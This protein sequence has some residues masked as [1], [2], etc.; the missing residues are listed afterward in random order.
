M[1]MD[2]NGFD[3]DDVD[4]HDGEFNQIDS[5]DIAVIGM[6][7][8]FPG[9]DDIDTFWQN[10]IAGK[11]SIASLT[12]EDLQVARV[13]EKIRTH[14]D[15][16]RSAATVDDIDQFDATYFGLSARE[17][18]LIDPQHRIFLQCVGHALNHS[19]YDSFRFRGDIGLYAGCS[20]S[21]YLLS[22]LLPH[23]EWLEEIGAFEVA[24]ANDKDY[25][26]SRAAYH[27]NLSGPCIAVQTACST[28]LVAV[29]MAV[30]GLLAGECDM[31]LAGGIT[32]RVPQKAGY[33]YRAG[34]ILSPDG[35]CRPF[36]RE[37]NGTIFGNGVGVV[38]LRRLADA[39]RDGD[40]IFAVIRGSAVANEGAG[41]AGFTAPS[42][43][44]QSKVIAEAIGIAGIEPSEIGY[45]ETHGTGTS[46][47]DPIELLALADVFGQGHKR[48]RPTILGAL[49]ANIGHLDSAAGVAGL[50]KTVLTLHH[51][52]IP[53]HPMYHEP[54]PASASVLSS[55]ADTLFSVNTV[56]ESWT[57]PHGKCRYASV[58]SFGIGGTNAHV[59]L[60]EAPVSAEISR[61]QGVDV[62]ENTTEEKAVV[63]TWSASSTEALANVAS[64][65][66][67]DIEQHGADA[68]KHIAVT[69]NSGR[70][71]C[72]WR[73]AVVVTGRDEAIER[74]R[75]D[76]DMPVKVSA[77]P[78]G[79]YALLFPGQGAQYGG[80]A[81]TLYREEALFRQYFDQV[82]QVLVARMQRDPCELLAAG[83]SATSS[84]NRTEVTQPLLFAVEYALGRFLIDR[85]GEPAVMA[86]HSLGE[87]AAAA[88]AGVMS[89]EDAV[90]LVCERG[91]MM[92][93]LPSGAMLAVPLPMQVVQEKTHLD[94]AVVN[95]PGLCVISG[96]EAEIADFEALHHDLPLRRL[97]TSH[98]FH[99]AMITPMVAPF[100]SL[101]ASVPLHPPRWPILSCLSGE[102]VDDM[103]STPAYW[104]RLTRETVRFD[105]VFSTLSQMGP[106]L[107]EAGPGRTLSLLAGNY[108]PFRTTK[109][110]PCMGGSDS[111]TIN[112]NQA[113]AQLWL[114]GHSIDW[115]AGEKVQRMSLSLYPFARTR[116][117]IE[118]EEL[119][120]ISDE[121]H[122]TAEDV[123]MSQHYSRPTS[124]PAPILPRTEAESL[125][126]G[127]WENVLGIAPIGVTDDFFE[128]GGHSLLA[129]QVVTRL[130]E[131]LRIELPL[132]LF[133]EARTVM[134]LA[135]RT[136]GYLA[137]AI[138]AMSEEEVAAV[139]AALE[140]NKEN[141]VSRKGDHQRYES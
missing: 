62:H 49:K 37:A 5:D 101:L 60:A 82:R 27:F 129:V 81:M 32:L 131:A 6:A 21:S 75:H 31:A 94:I 69:M 103:I 23:R 63:L 136:E 71:E 114:R 119:R 112:L 140:Q 70:R 117:W 126:T 66:A 83:V 98:A 89:L 59:V 128:L 141:E 111:E 72:L 56:P 16:V 123:A 51:G 92:G 139:M 88:L 48:Y 8:R 24:L 110:I 20:M 108:E 38:V 19:G 77:A 100:E 41:K 79:G 105:L 29:H 14:P 15:Y 84:L 3:S 87:F 36:D 74:L 1:D 22:N 122:R 106:T 61:H 25:L 93:A 33:L 30:Q 54:H 99:S 34:S 137:E 124:L 28:S 11:V 138:E 95:G 86:G 135:E 80:M 73:R 40:Q 2:S 57:E 12:E 91:R 102:R 107:L 58:S 116:Y 26:T 115:L 120:P 44:G 118:P 10:L 96:T 13:Q 76:Q 134:I 53:P 113:L 67:K 109:A 55:D 4:L 127:V 133:F 97:Q 47:G 125:V 78:A 50:I 17:A 9:A 121:T 68:L 132:E 90:W 52:V 43:S 39:M 64:A 46:L 7:G 130:R 104:G 45:V 65:L 42:I 85:L 18:A 35:M